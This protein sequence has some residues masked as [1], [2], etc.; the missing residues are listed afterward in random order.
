MRYLGL[1]SLVHSIYG[2]CLAI[3]YGPRLAKTNAVFGY[4]HQAAI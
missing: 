4:Q 1:Q 2:P 3:I